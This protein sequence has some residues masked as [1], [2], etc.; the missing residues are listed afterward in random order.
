MIPGNSKCALVTGAS[1]GVGRGVATALA[2]AG[3][4]TFGTGRSIEHSDLAQTVHRI[5]CDHASVEESQAAVAHVVA[6]AGT[7]DLLVNAAWGGYERMVEDGV[8]TWQVPFWQQPLHRWVSMLDV[9]VRS[10]FVCAQAAAPIM[11]REQRGL[12]VNLSFWAAQKY[13]GNSIY[14]VAKAA[15]DKM[16]SDFAHELHTHK[17]SVVSLY[18]G[19]VRT[20]SVLAASR[21]GW[22]DLSNSESPEFIG[23]VISALASDPHLLTRSGKVLIAASIAQ[24]LGIEDV[25]GRRPKPLTMQ[26]V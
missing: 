9:G 20:E 6:E 21:E 4:I 12:I 8:F 15:T 3:W 19:L 10:A 17:V 11:I 1:R 24:E 16:T 22:L 25:D 26:D 14:G 7:I 23:R 18:P 2:S 13:L 5:Q